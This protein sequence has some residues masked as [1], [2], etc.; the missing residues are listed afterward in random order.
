MLHLVGKVLVLL[1][2]VKKLLVVLVRDDLSA[3]TQ[4]NNAARTD[5]ESTGTLHL[6]VIF[7]RGILKLVPD[8]GAAELGCTNW[9][10]ARRSGD[11]FGFL[12]RLAV[13][14]RS[15]RSIPVRNPLCN[16]VIPLLLGLAL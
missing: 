12:G 4:E 5:T 11:A 2:L 7:I 14:G 16:L 8:S 3:I 9:P 13:L 1:G 15:T 6:Q 10:S